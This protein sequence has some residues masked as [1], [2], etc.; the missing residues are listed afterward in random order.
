MWRTNCRKK[1]VQQ[2]KKALNENL[3]IVNPSLRPALLNVR[4]M[5]YRIS[6]MGLCKV[7][8]GH[9][10]TLR[11]FKDAQIDQLREVSFCSVPLTVVGCRLLTI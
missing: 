1:K 6:D 7:E 3:F 10:Y 2:C 4:E 9:T 5:C 11:D 8:K